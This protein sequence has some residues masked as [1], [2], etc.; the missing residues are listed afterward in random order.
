MFSFLSIT[1]KFIQ[2]MFHTFG[3]FIQQV[4]ID[5]AS[6]DAGVIVKVQYLHQAFYH[7]HYYFL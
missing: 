6:P 7:F 5:V 3:D 1:K 4:T 2:S